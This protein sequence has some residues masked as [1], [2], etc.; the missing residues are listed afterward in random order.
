MPK[1]SCIFYAV[2]G[3][4]AK[5]NAVGKEEVAK[6]VDDTYRQ[7]IL[8]DCSKI[9]P[10]DMRMQTS[11]FIKALFS[12]FAFSSSVASLSYDLLLLQKP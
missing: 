11:C 12:R 5:K 7:V 4:W 1:L 9:A 6:L 2:S 8:F 10:R 3:M